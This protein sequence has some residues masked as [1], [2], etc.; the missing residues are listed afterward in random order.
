MLHA[1]ETRMTLS[2]PSG[3]VEAL[4]ALLAW[5][6]NPWRAL[7]LIGLMWTG[8]V[9]AIIW[10][11]RVTLVAVMVQDAIVERPITIDQARAA[12]VLANLLR[13]TRG[14]IALVSMWDLDSNRRTSVAALNRE[15]R[16]VGVEPESLP[17]IRTPRVSMGVVA[18][19]LAGDV[20]CITVPPPPAARSNDVDRIPPDLRAL[21]MS[22]GLVAYCVGPLNTAG[23]L[24]GSLTVMFDHPPQDEGLVAIAIR[25][26]ANELLVRRPRATVLVDTNG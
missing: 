21:S 23:N 11:Q 22:Y 6:R 15:G 10:D 18:S 19:L 13:E 25:R 26:A 14:T 4:R 3:W 8:L 5:L 17:I 2:L 12:P 20:P 24:I 16:R 7:V 1:L 9:T